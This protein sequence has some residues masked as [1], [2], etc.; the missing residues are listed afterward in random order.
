M[1]GRHTSFQ[2]F[3]SGSHNPFGSVLN[4][5]FLTESEVRK[6]NIYEKTLDFY[7]WEE[8]LGEEVYGC[9]AKGINTQGHLEYSHEDMEA[10]RKKEKT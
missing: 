4:K 7:P 5:Y 8:D 2:R 3:G 6:N 1:K 9:L 10:K